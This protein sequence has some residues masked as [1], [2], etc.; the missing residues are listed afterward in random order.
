[1]ILSRAVSCLLLTS[2]IA[3]VGTACGTDD[4]G[5]RSEPAASSAEVAGTATKH[6]VFFGGDRERITERWFTES[7]AIAGA[8]LKYTWVQIL[9]S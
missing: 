3:S 1:M 2:A 6:F 5:G 9:V 7:H 8:Q 4:A